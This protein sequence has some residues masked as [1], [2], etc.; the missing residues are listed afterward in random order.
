VPTATFSVPT[1]TESVVTVRVLGGRTV[2]GLI[3]GGVIVSPRAVLAAT[4]ESASL[5]SPAADS[6]ERWWWDGDASSLA[7]E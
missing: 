4:T 3:A 6:S 7:G 2:I 5:Q 1:E